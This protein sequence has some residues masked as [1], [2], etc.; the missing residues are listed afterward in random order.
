MVVES[1]TLMS[2]WVENRE[3]SAWDR[4]TEKMGKR[5]SLQTLSQNSAGKAC[6]CVLSVSKR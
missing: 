5:T 4:N 6:P 3:T 2:S 1:Q